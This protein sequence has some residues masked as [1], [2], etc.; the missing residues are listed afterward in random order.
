MAAAAGVEVRFPLVAIVVVG[1]GCIE[2]AVT[3]AVTPIGENGVALADKTPYPRA[4]RGVNSG[5]P[6]LSCEEPL[7]FA[8]RAQVRKING[9]TWR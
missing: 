8:E 4:E 9:H 6:G 1:F 2:S 7:S 5:A 3:V